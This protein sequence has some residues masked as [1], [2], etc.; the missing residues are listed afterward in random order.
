M[1]KKLFAFIVFLSVVHWVSAQTG[2]IRGKIIEKSTGE[3]MAG[4]N[5][6]IESLTI[7]TTAD[8]DGNYSLKATPGTYTVKISF[9][10]YNTVELTDVKVE[11]GKIAEANIVMEEA[12][13]GI[14]E[15]VVTAVRKMNSEAQLLNAMKSSTVVM[16]GV[17]SQ[18]ITKTQDRNASEVIR[19]IPG[20]SI[21]DDKFVIAR[22]LS[23][24]YNNVWINAGA[25]PSSEAD[26]RSFSFDMIPGS[27]IENIMIVK[28][29]A[30]ELPA[31][32]TGG[33][34]KVATKN[35][36]SENGIDISY[37]VNFNTETQFHDFKYNQG[38][39]T[40]FLGFDNGMRNMKSVSSL[41]NSDF[42]LDRLDNKN[43]AQ[44]TEMT[45]SGFNNDWA[46]HTR[47]PIPDQRFSV[48]LNRRFDTKGLARWGMIA[49]L[50]YTY[51]NRTYADMKNARYGVYNVS[52]DTSAY[53]YKYT[54]NQYTTDAR[55]GGMF[56]V[57]YM[58]ND[59]H[60]IEFRN[61]VNQLGRNRYTERVGFQY[62]SGKYEQAKQ[63]YV[64]SSRMTYSG[65][66]AG[67]HNLTDADKF[68][69]TLGYS[70]AN[71]NQPDRRIINLEENGFK[72]DVHYGEMQ[73]DQNEIMR[74]FVKLD[75]NIFSANVDY[76]H[77]FM[78]GDFKPVL[79]AGAYAEH[80]DREYNTR[81]FNYRWK[82][83][84]LPADFSYRDPV[85]GILISENYGA[86]KLYVYEETDS[87]NNYMGNNMMV[88]GYA[89]FE[90][91]LKKLNI[92]A[93]VRAENNRMSV[94]SYES[95]KGDITKTRDYDQFD[96]FPSV[97]AT[98]NFNNEHLLRFAYGASINRQ[99]F[100][101]VSPSVYY[102]FDLFSAIKGN[103]DLKPA[104]IQN[105]DLRYEFYPAPGELISL[106]AFYKKFNHPI[107]WTYL[108]AGGSYTYTFEN[109]QSAR[110][111]GLEL[112]IKKSFDFI[113]LPQLSLTL[114]GALIDSKVL[115]EE[116]SMEHDRPMQ[117][118]SPFLVNAG[119][120]YQDKKDVW[121]IGLLYN[122]IGKRIVGIGRVDASEGSTINN[123][124]P[125]MY[126]MPRNV[127]DLTLRRKIGK[128]FEVSAAVK[129]ILAQNVV[130]KQFPKFYDG[131]GKLQTR[132][133]TT[134]EFKPGQNIS[135]SLKMKF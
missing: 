39:A 84:N 104:Y 55:V 51:S 128:R 40:D 34:I 63:E 81:E 49:A 76:S 22:G 38:S 134:K 73:T 31:D 48:M 9:V 71:R 41:N 44:V 11:A 4:A 117:G 100:R 94:K 86:D 121:M 133:Q 132:E 131:T 79:K 83:E 88:A 82:E 32:F 10:S 33:F 93:G 56:N 85:T 23:Q 119:V 112:D 59:R 45:R 70:Y 62:I 111:Y 8:L 123:D 30:P 130:F 12:S 124:I 16:S 5:V 2:E 72:E 52:K 1:I 64:Y 127:L 35:M 42:A 37:G 122:I 7:G 108:D 53:L 15:V 58:M 27:Q 75:E 116:E 14:E 106:A 3:P 113:G 66:L 105:F 80:R 95:I 103:P 126:E 19:R 101:E 46:V 92:Y 50:N 26:T 25:V 98:Y 13:T 77:N 67:I 21:I 125:D 91:P 90:I 120:F 68:N 118:Q 20:I 24:R 115:F 54:D 129:D 60:R 36:P 110:N 65:Q 61:I 96:F 29:P 135:F 74:D 47:R 97:N 102:D 99:E 87:R 57:T 18:Q 107:E 17:S 69:W 114:N 6:V 43:T 109:A 28:S 78:F 89:G